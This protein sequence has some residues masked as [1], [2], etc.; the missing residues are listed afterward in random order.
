MEYT[1]FC[2]VTASNINSLMILV[3]IDNEPLYLKF[4]SSFDLTTAMQNI[5]SERVDFKRGECHPNI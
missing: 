5:S 1:V 4:L 3:K 2:D